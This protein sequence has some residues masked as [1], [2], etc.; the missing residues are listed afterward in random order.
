MTPNQSPRPFGPTRAL[1]VLL[2]VLLLT[3]CAR[4]S[5]APLPS[6]SGA[7]TARTEISGDEAGPKRRLCVKLF[8]SEIASHK[9]LLF[10]T[11]ASDTQKWAMAWSPANVLVL[12]SADVGTNAYEIKDGKIIERAASPEEREIGRE[13][14][15]VKYGKLPGA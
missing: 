2:S 15:K 9:E 7:L 5:A 11:D 6:P 8:I 14:Y 3:A 10:Q 4:S 1:I 12:Y 13:A